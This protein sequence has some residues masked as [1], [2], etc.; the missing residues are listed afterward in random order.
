MMRMIHIAHNHAENDTAFGTCCRLCILL[1]RK[2]FI[3]ASPV[4]L[5]N[6]RIYEQCEEAQ[7]HSWTPV[8]LLVNV[9]LVTDGVCCCLKT[10]L[11]WAVLRRAGDESGWQILS[12]G[13]AEESDAASHASHC[14]WHVRVSAARCTAASCSRDSSA[15]AAGDATIYL[16]RF[17]AS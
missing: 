9:L 10:G 3:V 6:D 16:A 14:R 4:N 12:Q 11:H 17:V 2:V 5:Q 15:A 1:W 7:H 8:A 13:F